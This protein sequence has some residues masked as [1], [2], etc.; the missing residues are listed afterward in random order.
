MNAKFFGYSAFFILVVFGISFFPTFSALNLNFTTT[1][2]FPITTTTFQPNCTD[3]DGGINIFIRGY[4]EQ[5]FGLGGYG[6]S[7]TCAYSTNG[8]SFVSECY[9]VWGRIN[10]TIRTC[11]SGYSCSNGA[12][13]SSTNVTNCTDSDGGINYFVKGTVSLAGFPVATDTCLNCSSSNCTSGTLIEYYCSSSANYWHKLFNCPNGCN[14]GACLQPIPNCVGRWINITD[15]TKEG[16]NISVSYESMGVGSNVQ[17]FEKIMTLNGTS[18][19]KVCNI[20]IGVCGVGPNTPMSC[21]VN[22]NC[23]YPDF[24]PGYRYFVKVV[25]A[26]CR[27]V[28]DTREIRA[29]GSIK[30]TVVEYA[31][32]E[33]TSKILYNAVVSV[34]D[35]QNNLVGTRDTSGGAAVFNDLPAGDYLASASAPGYRP[36]KAPFKIAS[37]D[38]GYLTIALN[39]SVYNT[40]SI[41][42]TIVERNNRM[43]EIPPKPAVG[44]T[45]D[46]NCIIS[47]SINCASVE[48]ILYNARVSVYDWMNNLVGTKNTSSGAAVFYDLP[49]GYYVASASAPGHLPAKSRFRIEPGIMG[50]LKIALE[51]SPEPPRIWYRNAYWQCYDGHEE[52]MGGPLSCKPASAWYG[53]AEQSCRN[54]CSN[55]TYGNCTSIYA[56]CTARCGVKSFKVFNE[57]EPGKPDKIPVCDK[58]G[59]KSEGWYLDGELIKYD[60]CAC[61]AVCKG[62]GTRSEGYY[63]SCTGELIQYANCGSEGPVPFEVIPPRPVI[64]IGGGIV[65]AG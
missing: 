31:G 46:S 28:S 17:I 32:S 7:D 16:G 54:R 18:I 23:P 42:I 10:T 29:S 44:C 19:E 57:C 20:L 38:R 30:I 4:C 26:S 24:A 11:P 63:S 33:N 1:T 43:C 15:I 51:K 21:S 6:I 2:A 8:S 61:T 40:G 55:E 47:E 58:I 36:A 13:A 37:G 35:W 45:P 27:N 50:Y 9:C 59:T 56:N 22:T 14:D 3:S 34:Y 62:I 60:K 41:N 39:K 48:R 25:D 49:V 65:K 52:I 53:H 5:N 12:C 64:P